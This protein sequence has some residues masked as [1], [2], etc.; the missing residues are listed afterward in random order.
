MEC[1]VNASG[2][3]DPG[4]RSHRHHAKRLLRKRRA[5]LVVIPATL[6]LLALFSGKTFS[7]SS[8]P[9][10][11]GRV[12]ASPAPQEKSKPVAPPPNKD[13]SAVENGPRPPARVS[14]TSVVADEE[15]NRA[16]RFKVRDQSGQCVVARLY[17]QYRNE[18]ALIL[19]DGQLGKPSHLVPTTEPFQP[20]SSSDLLTLL[21]E[22]NGP[23]EGYPVLKTEHY[24]IFY[25]STRAFAEDS[26]ELL[27]DLYRG[28][29]DTFRRNNVAV[30]ES[31]FPL[32]AV[33]FANEADFRAHKPVDPQVPRV[34]RILHE[35]DF[36]LPEIR[37]GRARAQGCRAPQAADRGP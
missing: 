26:A 22:N 24:L 29:I 31:E 28:L 20:L 37:A 9:A 19:P 16:P 2:G 36:L 35:S 13:R 30:H 12:V 4:V 18:T 15:I 32:V 3:C 14:A 11:S 5:V 17:G 34:L 1:A 23:F 8:T 21:H 27:E 10:T 25:K 7:Q 6:A 33:V